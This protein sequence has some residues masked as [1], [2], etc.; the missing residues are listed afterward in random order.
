MNDQVILAFFSSL[1]AKFLPTVILACCLCSEDSV[2]LTGLIY[3][4]RL[5]TGMMIN[6]VYCPIFIHG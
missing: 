4:S 5:N 6:L 2:T 3:L 1:A